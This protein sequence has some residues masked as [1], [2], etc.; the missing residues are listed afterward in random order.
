MHTEVCRA[1][2]GPHDIIYNETKTVCMLVRPKQSQGWYSARVRLGNEELRL[3][4]ELRYQGHVMTADCQDK[5]IK[6]QFRRQ[7]AVR[8]MLVRKF[9]LNLCREKFNCSSHIVT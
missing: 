6:K 2:T 4:E 9:S 3:V 8:N 7:N 5:D 1:Y